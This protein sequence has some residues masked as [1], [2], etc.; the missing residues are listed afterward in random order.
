MKRLYA[1]E[2]PAVGVCRIFSVCAQQKFSFRNIKAIADLFPYSRTNMAHHIGVLRLTKTLPGI[3]RVSV[4][5]RG[6]SQG[7]KAQ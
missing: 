2:E 5:A 4:L 6:V 7:A 3:C 1:S